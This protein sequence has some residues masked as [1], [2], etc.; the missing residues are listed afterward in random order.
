M[1]CAGI[2]WLYVGFI[3]AIIRSRLKPLF[4]APFGMCLIIDDEFERDVKDCF[5][6]EF[7]R[8]F[9]VVVWTYVV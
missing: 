9:F 2:K 8:N 5:C 1:S 4:L 7:L 6:G 3:L